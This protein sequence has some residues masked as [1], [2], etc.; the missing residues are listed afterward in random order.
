MS[1]KYKKIDPLP[2]EFSPKKRLANSGIHIVLQIMRNTWNLLNS[3]QISKDA[4]SRLSWMKKV[5]SLCDLIPEK[6]NSQR[7]NW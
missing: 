4:I 6:G 5:F 7:N 3:W 2:D 1:E